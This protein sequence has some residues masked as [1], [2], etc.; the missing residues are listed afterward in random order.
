MIVVAPSSRRFDLGPSKNT[1]YW[2]GGTKNSHKSDFRS[3]IQQ[4]SK[5]LRNFRNRFLVLE[6]SRHRKLTC[7][8]RFLIN[9]LV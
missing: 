1:T 5:G 3:E 7:K 4:L 6:L 2:E 9:S 8:L